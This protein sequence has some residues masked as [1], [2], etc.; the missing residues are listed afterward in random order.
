ML[1]L[2]WSLHPIKA[3]LAYPRPT[4][5]CGREEPMQAGLGFQCDEIFTRS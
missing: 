1:L 2:L 5:E 3:A 4:W